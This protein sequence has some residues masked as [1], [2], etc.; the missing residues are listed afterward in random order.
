MLYREGQDLFRRSQVRQILAYLRQEDR[1]RYCNELGEL[2]SSER[3]RFHLHRFVFAWLS[4]VSDPQLDEWI[5]IRSLVDRSES[6]RRSIVGLLRSSERWFVLSNENGDTAKWLD[7]VD[8]D[9]ID[10]AVSILVSHTKSNAAVVGALLKPHLGKSVL[11]N[12]RIAWVL[13]LAELGQDRDLF[14]MFLRL[15]AEGTF[16]ERNRSN[17]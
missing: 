6:K 1:E 4:Q 16:D 8:N 12:R 13:A 10:S 7:S 9:L 11:W 5:T 3:I 2:L 14:E 15:T 17:G